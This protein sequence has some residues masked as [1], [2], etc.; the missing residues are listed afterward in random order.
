MIYIVTACILGGGER[1]FLLSGVAFRL[2]QRFRT[3]CILKDET[4]PCVLFEYAVMC[5]KEMF[6]FMFTL[7]FTTGLLNRLQNG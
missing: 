7:R 5:I 3:L 4:F 2:L 6:Y 1:N